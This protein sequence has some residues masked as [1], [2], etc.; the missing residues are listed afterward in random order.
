MAA[1][2][3]CCIVDAPLPRTFTKFS[4]S[5]VCAFTSSGIPDKVS[6]PIPSFFV[7]LLDRFSF[8]SPRIEDMEEIPD[9]IEANWSADDTI[10]LI[11]FVAFSIEYPACVNVSAIEDFSNA[12]SVS[13]PASASSRTFSLAS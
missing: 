1:S 4:Y 11:F 5:S 10:S 2:L 8:F 3:H 12:F 6:A 13:L 9:F 7:F